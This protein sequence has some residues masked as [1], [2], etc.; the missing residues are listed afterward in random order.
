[1]CSSLRELQYLFVELQN[2]KNLEKDVSFVM[3]VCLWCRSYSKTW[4]SIH[5][6]RRWQQRTDLAVSSL[7]RM[8]RHIGR[9]PF[10]KCNSP[11]TLT[12]FHS[13]STTQLP[14]ML[15]F[16]CQFLH[17]PAKSKQLPF[18][19]LFNFRVISFELSDCMSVTSSPRRL[20]HKIIV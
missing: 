15:A 17:C 7:Y 2:Q 12:V 10:A 8:Y 9:S 13:F 16:H 5:C 4:Q 14:C 3:V 1:M 19:F 18:H 6:Q 11:L 20:A